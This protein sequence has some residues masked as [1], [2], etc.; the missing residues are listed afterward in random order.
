MVWDPQTGVS[1]PHSPWGSRGAPV[2]LSWRNRQKTAQT[3]HTPTY[4][5]REVLKRTPFFYEN[6][7]YGGGLS[8]LGQKS[9]PER[10]PI[11]QVW[12]P[13][14]TVLAFFPVT[15]PS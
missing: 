14:M 13:C 11:L 4:S 5:I 3:G 1:D 2:G 6:T 9:G 7:I 15:P 10:S 8:F 12:G